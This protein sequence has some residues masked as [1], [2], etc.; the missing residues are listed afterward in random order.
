MQKIAAFIDFPS[1]CS[2]DGLSYDPANTADAIADPV[3]NTLSTSDARQ[4]F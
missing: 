4:F 2:P 3:K 1:D